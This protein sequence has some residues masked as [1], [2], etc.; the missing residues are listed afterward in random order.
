MMRKCAAAAVA[1]ILATPVWA[2]DS[3]VLIINN[4]D[5]SVLQ[6]L[7]GAGNLDALQNAFSDLGMDA[8]LASRANG[9]A[10]R[11]AFATF[12]ST[13]D[14]ASGDIAMALT[15]QFVSTD[16]GTYLLPAGDL[17]DM[18]LGEVLT[19]GLP[20][21]AIYA[22]AA[23][24][25][26]RA[27]IVLGE[28]EI[29]DTLPSGLSLDVPLIDVPQGV[30][31]AIGPAGD[32]LDFFAQLPA[33]NGTDVL[34]MVRNAGLALDGFV[35][36]TL[37]LLPHPENAPASVSEGDAVEEPNAAD[38]DAWQQAVSANTEAS[39]DAYLTAFPEGQNAA[40]ARQRLASIRA[41][42]FFREKQIET[43]LALSRDA[44]RE[45]QRDLSL[46]GYN[47]RGI[48]GIFGRGTRGAVTAWQNEN[49]LTASGY[50]NTDQIARLDAQ[51]ERRAAELEEEA[52]LRQAEL[53]R[54][55]R[56]F[57]A[58]TGARGDE[59]G[60]RAYLKRFP[61]GVFAETAQ[62]QLNA[63]EEQRRAQAEG[64]D[65]A[66]WQVARQVDTEA[67]YRAYLAERPNGAFVEEARARIEYFSQNGE[68]IAIQ[69]QAQ[70]EENGLG[71]NVAARRL[72]EQRLTG[73]GLKPGTVDGTFDEDT[74]RALRRYQDAR[75][76][77]VS[78]YLDQATLVRLMADTILR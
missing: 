12:V 30:T 58:E 10:M 54:Q 3:D 57:W 2:S 36:Q 68:Q 65:R 45:I 5:P 51:A 50:L 26:A 28:V 35:P 6:R 17:R 4:S 24:F 47:T 1:L 69:R 22:V 9:D 34:P 15:G 66:R 37:P 63:I 52:R 8:T 42:P 71:L 31:V 61:D 14:F 60:Y 20:L 48:D 70:A 11:S 13:V 49:G 40:E 39:Y 64:E 44:R 38:T 62:G 27:L 72:A 18:T 46:L 53:E 33:A 25:P 32:A 55:D 59:P 41:E 77:R 21:D 67:G 19:E 78:G 73:L 76:L 7:T 43:D 16:Q 23:Q 75:R 56:A 74:R 29:D